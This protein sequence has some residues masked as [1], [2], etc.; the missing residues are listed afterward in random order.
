M[1][2]GGLYISRGLDWQCGIESG[3][4]R[5]DGWMTAEGNKLA[6]LKRA[7]VD[8]WANERKGRIACFGLNGK[9]S[10][11]KWQI[12]WWPKCLKGI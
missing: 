2:V 12:F 7:K 5:G 10:K 4:G 8:E 3:G 9:L 11:G 1:G 6:I